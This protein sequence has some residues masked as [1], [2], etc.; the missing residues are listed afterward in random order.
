MC[1]T[2]CLQLAAAPAILQ[3]AVA[4]KPRAS[5]LCMDFTPLHDLAGVYR[6]SSLSSIY[7]LKHL[8]LHVARAWASIRPG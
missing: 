2:V 6:S 8:Q 4:V 5:F 3:S 1:K 7:R